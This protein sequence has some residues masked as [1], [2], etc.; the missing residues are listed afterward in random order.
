MLFLLSD[1]SSHLTG[2]CLIL[3]G[4]HLRWSHL[5]GDN[6]PAFLKDEAFR[7]SMKR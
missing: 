3:D 5:I 2:Q 7:E 6:T 1:L 4:G